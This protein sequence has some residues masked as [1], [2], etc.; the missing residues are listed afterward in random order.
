MQG[1]CV[2]A[3]VRPRSHHFSRLTNGM[4]CSAIAT[5]SL[6]STLNLTP[7]PKWGVMGM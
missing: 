4:A 5:S 7:S 3:R 2:E 1:R 6:V